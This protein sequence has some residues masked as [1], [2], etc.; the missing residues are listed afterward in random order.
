MRPTLPLDVN[1]QQAAQAGATWTLYETMPIDGHNFFAADIDRLLTD[2]PEIHGLS[3]P[4]MPQGSPGMPGDQLA[5][6]EILAFDDGLTS[7]FGAY[8]TT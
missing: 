8:A 5:P 6:F 1:I 2:R 3:V 4:G 7:V